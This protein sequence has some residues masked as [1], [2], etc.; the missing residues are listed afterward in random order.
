MS[1]VE[2]YIFGRQTILAQKYKVYAKIGSGSFGDIYKAECKETGERVAVK[3][4]SL[5]SFKPLILNEYKMYKIVSRGTGIPHVYTCFTEADVNVLVMQLLGPSLNELFEYCGRRFSVKT[6]AMLA[7]QMIERLQHLHSHNIVH[8]DIKPDNFL[9]GLGAL[10]DQLFIIDLGLAKEYWNKQTEK[11]IQPK[12]GTN[13]VGTARYASINA[14]SGGQ[15]SRRDDMEALGYLMIYLLRGSL[16]WQ[17]I[18]NGPL[19]QRNE[20]I[21]E[22][23]QSIRLEELCSG[24]PD[25]FGAYMSYCR[26]LGF[27]E[28]PH[29]PLI[30]QS[31]LDLMKRFKYTNDGVFD[32]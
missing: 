20:K 19:K 31:F 18:R 25:E 23:K 22:Y 10:K 24:C 7:D 16:P 13:L 9:M 12:P 28:E 3:L 1:D 30:R 4:E 11:H 8:R 26:T 17:G 21:A 15:Q 6:V 14:M 2:E 5:N 27:E 32:W 29:Y